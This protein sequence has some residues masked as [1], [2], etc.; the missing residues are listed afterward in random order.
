[1]DLELIQDMFEI[2]DVDNDIDGLPKLD[3]SKILKERSIS[4]VASLKNLAISNIANNINFWM[5]H[6]PK[7][8]ELS[9]YVISPFDML[10]KFFF[11]TIHITIYCIHT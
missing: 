2:L 9:L 10:S 4:C 7:N 11:W 5:D 8:P 1:M 6:L 3:L